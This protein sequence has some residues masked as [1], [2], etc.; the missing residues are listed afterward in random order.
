MEA[1]PHFMGSI[2]TL[3]MV[4]AQFIY[5]GLKPGGWGGQPS[6]PAINGWVNIMLIP[7]QFIRLASSTNTLK[8][9]A[10]NTEL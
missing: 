10:T 5:V 1:A 6:I 8:D 7:A 4:S 3:S 9:G 2:P